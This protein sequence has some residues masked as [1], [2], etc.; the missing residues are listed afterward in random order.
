V[1]ALRRLARGAEMAGPAYPGQ[2]GM[3]LEP[4]LDA[5]RGDESASGRYV[6]VEGALAVS[7]V[8]ASVRILSDSIGSLPLHV[9][10]RDASGRVKAEGSRSYR[11]LHEDPNPEMPASV[12]WSLV[13]AHLNT[14]GNAY[15]GKTFRGANVTELWP[16]RPDRVTV[17]REKGVKVF[18]V[19]DEHGRQMQQT[20]TARE[21]IHLHGLT[22]DGM[23]GLSP[24]GMARE[25][26]GAA[27]AMDEYSNSFFKN[28][29]LPR[30]VLRHKQS[31]SQQAKRGLR[32]DWE[33]RYRGSKNANRVAV[34]EEDMDVKVL[35]LPQRDLEFVEQRRHSVAE[36]ARWFRIPPTMLG[37]GREGSLTYETVEGDAIHFVTHS[38]RPWL[39]RIEQSL[40][41]DPDLFPTRRLYSEFAVDALLR[42]DTKTRYEAH[43]IALD[44]ISGWMKPAEVRQ[45]ENLPPDP[46][47]D[48]PTREQLPSP[49]DEGV[50]SR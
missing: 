6:S 49:V 29:A 10:R 32:R 22:L 18:R 3:D 25:S 17:G 44:P 9:Y 11:L 27:L 47:F 34:L 26:I 16:I 20:F 15:L 5:W 14:W 21:I 43:Q 38:L 8:W 46:S 48:V 2:P 37:G 23:V 12:L 33:R 31:L 39:V 1:S 24:V 36:I 4:F 50:P 7:A 45:L 35:T 30:M 19:R 40:N 41:R 28:G 13:A 42:A